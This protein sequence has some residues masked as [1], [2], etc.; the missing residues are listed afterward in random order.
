MSKTKKSDMF[1]NTKDLVRIALNDGMTQIEIANRCRSQQSQV[2]KWKSGER[3]ATRQQLQ[4]LLERYGERLRRISF[5]LYQTKHLPDQPA[6]FVKVEG[7]LILREKFRGTG[8]PKFPAALRVSVHDQKSGGF[9]VVAEVTEARFPYPTK[10]DWTT[11]L[12]TDRHAAWFLDNGLVDIA[13][14]DISG[15]ISW[16]NSAGHG[17]TSDRFPGLGQLPFLVTEALLNHGFKPESVESFK[18]P[19]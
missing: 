2:S 7:K 16:S 14:H 3:L 15:L 11:P 1:T 9:A 19:V 12:I 17:K 4:P 8:E 6:K 10:K 18:I 5:K 13:M